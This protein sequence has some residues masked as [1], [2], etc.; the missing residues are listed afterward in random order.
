MLHKLR[1]T[2]SLCIAEVMM[3]LNPVQAGIFFMP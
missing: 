3:G 2:L 1:N